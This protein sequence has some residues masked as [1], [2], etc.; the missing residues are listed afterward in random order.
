MSILIGARSGQKRNLDLELDL[1]PPPD[2]NRDQ[3][4]QACPEYREGF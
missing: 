3:R 2:S 4:G 1:N